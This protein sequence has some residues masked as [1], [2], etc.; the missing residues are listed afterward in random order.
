MGT[1]HERVML[2]HRTYDLSDGSAANAHQVSGFTK[3]GRLLLTFRPDF[4]SNSSGKPC[5]GAS[6]ICSN[7]PPP[8]CLLVDAF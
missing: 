2:A 7:T 3:V 5:L 1:I 6:P 8:A 4:F